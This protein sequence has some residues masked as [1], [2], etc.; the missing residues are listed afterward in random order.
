MYEKMLGEKS[1]RHKPSQA[2]LRVPKT[3]FDFYRRNDFF[4]ILSSLFFLLHSSVACS[5]FLHCCCSP[6][7]RSLFLRILYS[8]CAVISGFGRSARK[9]KATRKEHS[10]WYIRSTCFIAYNACRRCPFIYGENLFER[11]TWTPN[12]N[13]ASEEK[14]W[15]ASWAIIFAFAICSEC[16]AKCVKYVWQW[17]IDEF[18][19]QR[20]VKSNK[21]KELK[22]NLESTRSSSHQHEHK[23]LLFLWNRATQHSSRW[24]FSIEYRWHCAAR[25]SPF[26]LV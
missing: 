9:V 10:M 18:I 23:W 8:I 13:T 5:L 20:I 15:L 6:V 2:D 22:T 21:K 26:A 1:T 25:F 19:G 7:L 24:T 14:K 16:C 3:T 11:R 12:A 17:A 4:I